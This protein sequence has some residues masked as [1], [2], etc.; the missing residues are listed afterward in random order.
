[1]QSNPSLRRSWQTVWRSKA[2]MA[3]SS[4]A[5]Q[6][7]PS[8][9][10]AQAPERMMSGCTRVRVSAAVWEALKES[11]TATALAATER[12]IATT[13]AIAT[14]R[15]MVTGSFTGPPRQGRRRRP[16][17]PRSPGQ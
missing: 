13:K 5:W 7:S 11:A 1:M 8:G 14:L 6:V 17:Q 9:L 15:R 10:S 4:E 2:A 3:A 16:A 12:T